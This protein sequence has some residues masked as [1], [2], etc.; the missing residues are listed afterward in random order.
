MRTAEQ[1]DRMRQ[2]NMDYFGFG[3]R[4]MRRIKVCAHCGAM[5]PSTQW[6]CRECG[7]RLP[8][9]TLF[10]FYQSRHK[11]CP[12]CETVVVSSYHYCPQC[13]TMLEGIGEPPAEGGGGL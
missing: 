3:P 1:L 10:Q 4:A 11:S 6:F 13:G 9:D 12:T 5:S 7:K 2:E 8:R